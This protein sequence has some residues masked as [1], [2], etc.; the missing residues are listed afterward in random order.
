MTV[1][2]SNIFTCIII[3]LMAML[4]NGDFG[5]KKMPFYGF[6]RH[7]RFI[8]QPYGLPYFFVVSSLIEINHNS[9]NGL[10]LFLLLIL[11]QIGTLLFVY[12]K[13]Y[14]KRFL[15]W[16]NYT[17]RIKEILG[18][19]LGK[20]SAQKTSKLE[21]QDIAYLLQNLVFPSLFV[22]SN[23]YLIVQIIIN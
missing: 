16:S 4:F 7:H 19:Y 13:Y 3:L 23:A 15:D 17:T 5:T 2:L 9:V 21:I 8:Q 20:K 14:Q 12:S 10:W 1:L 6:L 11:A 18:K 22:L